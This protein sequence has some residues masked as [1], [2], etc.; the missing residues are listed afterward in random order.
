[1]NFNLKAENVELK[2]GISG[3]RWVTET[4][5]LV[6]AIDEVLEKIRQSY[7]FKELIL[8][9]PLAEGADRIVAKRTLSLPSARLLILLPFPIKE[10][11][12]DFSSMESKGE[13]QH[14]FLQ[15]EQV[16][17]LPG[18]ADR[19]EAYEALGRSLLDQCDVLIAVWDGNP[20][21]GKGGTEEVVQMARERGMPLAWIFY[22]Q[23]DLNE[24][25]VNLEEE[26]QGGVI[27]ERFPGE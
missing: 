15:A 10:Y 4:N 26:A 9:S 24:N 6:N 25:G 8:I 27:F 23:L 19:A 5:K 11:L 1:M 12:K 2:I 22:K 3:H 18:S 16:Q 7:S 21:K 20:A 14:L 17:V 13:F